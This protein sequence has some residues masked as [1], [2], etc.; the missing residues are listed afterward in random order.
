MLSIWSK[1]DWVYERYVKRELAGA[2]A[3]ESWIGK[4]L[5]TYFVERSPPALFAKPT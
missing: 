2:P 4:L 1:S 3:A 5:P